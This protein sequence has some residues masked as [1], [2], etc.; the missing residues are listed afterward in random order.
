MWKLKSEVERKR[1]C[2]R[3]GL[4]EEKRVCWDCIIFQKMEVNQYYASLRFFDFER[5]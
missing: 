2:L 4:E 1:V 3:C 5:I